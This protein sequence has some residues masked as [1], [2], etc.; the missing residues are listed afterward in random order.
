MTVVVSFA[1]RPSW[2]RLRVLGIGLA[3]AL[4]ACDLNPQPEVPG[5]S[6]SGGATSGGSG[7]SA[8]GGGGGG[9]T[10]DAGT[11]GFGHAPPCAPDCASG[12]LCNRGKCVA[13]PCEPNTCDANEACKP[14]ADFTA[15]GCFGSCAT[16]TCAPGEVCQN[17]Q[18]EATGCATDCDVGEACLPATDAG[19]ECVPDPC[20]GRLTPCAD[21][22]VCDPMTN[23]CVLDPCT[24]VKCP[25]LQI[26]VAGECELPA[27]D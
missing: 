8:A 24:G 17:G 1:L 23:T 20:V 14:Q 2:R 9:I 18:C 21:G 25:Q 10:V 5:S 19:Y 16:V 12:E 15:A 13:D 27:D 6:A 7:G 3:L 4:G 26:C 22:G 11:G